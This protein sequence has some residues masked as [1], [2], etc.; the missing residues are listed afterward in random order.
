MPLVFSD[1]SMP[2]QLTWLEPG[3]SFP[4]V[5]PVIALISPISREQ[6]WVTWTGEVVPVN[7]SASKYPQRLQIWCVHNQRIQM[8]RPALTSRIW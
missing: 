4:T 5:N 2:S 3:D 7:L 8:S 6:G 1:P